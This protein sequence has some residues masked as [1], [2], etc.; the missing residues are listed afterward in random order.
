L[1]ET[2]AVEIAGLILVE[3][4]AE[5]VEVEVRKFVMPEARSV[6]VRV[7]GPGFAGSNLIR[8]TALDCRVSLR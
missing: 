1:I 3:F 4:G 8:T 7:S 5:R 2:I 6:A